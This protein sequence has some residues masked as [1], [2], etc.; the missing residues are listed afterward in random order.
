[1]WPNYAFQLIQCQPIGPVD[2][3]QSAG[4]NCLLRHVNLP[5]DSQAKFRDGGAKG[6][7]NSRY[8]MDAGIADAAF[9]AADVGRMQA[10]FFSQ[11]FLAQAKDLAVFS[12]AKPKCGQD[13]LSFRHAPYCMGLRAKAHRR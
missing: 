7:G 13:R 9:D 1:L 2:G 10:G 6:F 4:E 3:I 8:A 12:D 5:A 11:R